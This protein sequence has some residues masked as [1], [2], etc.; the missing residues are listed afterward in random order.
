V[1]RPEA[2]KILERVVRLG[3]SGCSVRMKSE[4]LRDLVAGLQLVGDWASATG[5]S[6]RRAR[7]GSVMMVVM[8]SFMMGERFGEQVPCSRDV[9]L[10][11][12]LRFAS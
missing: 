12:V 9:R 11:K 10:D 6:V 1:R 2:V 3:L 4:G 5:G 8:E 7:E